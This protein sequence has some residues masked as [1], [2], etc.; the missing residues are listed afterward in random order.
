MKAGL[1]FSACMLFLCACAPAGSSGV[2]PALT[3]LPAPP[4][5]Q[6]PSQLPLSE[7]GPYLAGLRR[8]VEFVDAGREDRKVTLT[9][10]YPAAAPD[11]TEPWTEP[12]ADVPP[13]ATGAPYPLILTATKLGFFFAPHLASHGFVVAGINGQDSSMNWGPWLTDHPRDLVFALDQIAAQ[14][15]PDLEGMIDAGHAGAMGY[16]F[17]SPTALF[18]GGARVDPDNYLQKCAN[19]PSMT[20]ALEEWWIDYNCN[21]LGGWEAFVANAGPAASGG[22]GGL[23]APITDDRIRAVIP[24]APEGDWL[25]GERGLQAVDRPTL[26]FGAT[27]DTVNPYALEA[28]PIYEKLNPSQRA[29]ISFVGEGHMMLDNAGRLAQMEHFA[30]AFFGLHLRGDQGLADYLSQDF[31]EKYPDLA[32]GVYTAE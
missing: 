24:M 14:G 17:G 22:E 31:V 32:W 19:A 7:P 1:V 15:V 29:M 23:W 5:T 10:W 4:A 3:T 11:G 16:S 26:I 18:L 21:L 2:P 13:D 9:V 8:N 20:P 27:Q 28:I 25:F 30:A 12:K 6:E